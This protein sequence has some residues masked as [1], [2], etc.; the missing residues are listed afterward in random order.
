MDEALVQDVV[1]VAATRHC[2]VCHGAAGCFADHRVA[3]VGGDALG[4]V[5]GGGITQGDVVAH[6]VVVED[7]AGLIGEPFGGDASGGGIQAGLRLHDARHTAAARM[8]DSGTTV[9]ATAKWL[10]H[11]P[12]MTLRI[13]GH[14]YEDTLASAGDAL[15][16]GMFP[17]NGEG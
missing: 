17:A 5:H 15:L 10:G 2:D 11:D 16:G 13:Y 7:G 3:G 6:V 1:V 12:A 9:S 14:I 8:L 4:G